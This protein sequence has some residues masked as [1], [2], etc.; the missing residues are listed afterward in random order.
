MLLLGTTLQFF[1]IWNILHSCCTLKVLFWKLYWHYNT[2]FSLEVLKRERQEPSRVKDFLC[3][4]C[5]DCFPGH[6]R[7][8]V[9][10]PAVW[11]EI[12]PA[13]YWTAARHMAS[14]FFVTVQISGL[15]QVT[16]SIKCLGFYYSSMCRDFVQVTIRHQ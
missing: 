4:Y 9:L 16:L 12:K 7:F 5:P 3:V 6:R 1:V 15:G 11:T 10:P 13:S 14:R 2:L 8:S